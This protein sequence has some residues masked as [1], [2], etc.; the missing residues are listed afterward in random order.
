[1]LMIDTI[2]AEPNPTWSKAY[3]PGD[4]IFDYFDDVVKKHDLPSITTYN[5]NVVKAVWQKRTSTWQVTVD[6]KGD[7]TVRSVHEADFLIG[8]TGHLSNP[9]HPKF[10][11]MESFKGKI[12]HTARWDKSY[13]LEGKRVACIGTG[14]TACQ[15]VPAIVDS[16]QH[17]TVFQRTP[18]WVFPYFLDKTYDKQEIQYFLDNPEMVKKYRDALWLA[19]ESRYG[20]T[21]AD[22]P[23]QIQVREFAVKYMEEMIPDPKLRAKL[24][25][26]FPAGCKRITP[27]NTYYGALVKPNCELVTDRIQ[28]LTPEG[29]VTAGPDGERLHPVDCIITATGFDVRFIPSFPIIGSNGVS[30]EELWNAK[31][32]EAFKTGVG[33]SGFPNYFMIL[34]PNS[35]G[36]GNSI[37]SSSEA[38]AIYAVNAIATCTLSGIRTLD[39]KKE[40]QDAW[41]LK[42]QAFLQK[43]VFAGPCVS[44]YKTSSGKITAIYPGT[45]TGLAKEIAKIDWSDYN[46]TFRD[47]DERKNLTR[48]VKAKDPEKV[49]ITTE[50]IVVI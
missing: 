8:A 42:G 48:K 47:G 30:I 19:Y 35:S 7:R 27:S 4:E 39:V 24:L 37:L 23:V 3:A 34:G 31:G 20:Y 14:A 1:M 32:A 36:G 29:I 28:R 38:Q 26:N 9:N 41:N 40:V 2:P 10:P 12:M 5:A 49:E 21:Q 13:N 11:G 6:V 22:S 18:G 44:W 33:V 43:T 50:E 15:V 25:P 16:V 45:K 17:L 46:I